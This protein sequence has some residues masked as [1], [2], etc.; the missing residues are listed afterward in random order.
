MT[1]QTLNTS[2]SK[3]LRQI[4]SALLLGIGV[5]VVLALV[6]S[7]A[8]TGIYHNRILP[9]V[10]LNGVSLAGMSAEKASET[11]SSTYSFPQAGHILLKDSESKWMVT[12]SQLGVTLDAQASAQNALLI[13]RSGSL[14][15][16]VTDT[17]ASVF[18][19]YSASPTFLFDENKALDYLVGLAGQINQ[20]MK[21]AGLK[22]E[23]SEVIITQGQPGRA[24]DISASL[25]AISDQVRKMQ[26]GVVELAIIEEQPR[27]MDVSQQGE[28][29][30]EI[31]SQPLTLSLPAGQTNPGAPWTIEPV[32]L[33]KI[34]TFAEVADGQSTK[35]VVEV[36]R[37]VM[38]GYLNTIKGDVSQQPENARFI[39]NDDTRQ[40]DLYAPAVVGRMLDIENSVTA[41][42][43]ALLQGK[44]SAELQVILTQPQVGDSATAADLGITEL[45][46]QQST[47]F[48]GSSP[49]RVHNIE[50]GAEKFKGL[51]IAPGQ[52]VS[53]SD[54]LGD[55][56]L[57]N[58]YAEA[59]IIFGDET[60][61]G[62][63]GGICQVSTTLFRT[64]L[65][66]G[67]PI[68]ERSAHSYRVK[69]YEQ[70]ASG[71]DDSLA[72][73]DATVFVP[74]VDFRFT[75]DT[76]YWLLM[77]TYVNTTDYRLTWKFYSTSD[78]RE[79]TISPREMTDITDPPDPLYR[80]NPDLATGV[81]KQVEYAAQ[82][83]TVTFDRVVTRGGQVIDSDHFVTH[84]QAWQAVYEYG[85][86]TEGIPTPSPN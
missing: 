57:N 22:I 86:G 67:F 81:K 56:S 12:P 19:G 21:D 85:P 74:L 25:Q 43:D 64:A 27:V 17:F 23:N 42:N 7:L 30:K 84:Y 76:P 34:L 77:E 61:Q 50:T 28:Q 60:I 9:G 24:L 18:F 35:V 14:F 26:D 3:L 41:I 80:E 54:I 83:A 37:P 73:M 39:F 16:R 20:P 65:H 72:G 52:E 15:T 10:T 47:Y 53:M 68:V 38:I 51:L 59:P 8:I 36:N 70:T 45:V 79:V 58:G 40:L 55:I 2:K 66:A 32:D 1:M 33:A 46:S 48:R 63:G 78:G 75:N 69:Y 6:I 44:H 62:V 82:G 13:G 29:V 71:H 5:I 49:D 31:L 4:L 11:V